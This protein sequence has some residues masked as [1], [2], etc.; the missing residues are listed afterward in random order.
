MKVEWEKSMDIKN[1]V[2]VSALKFSDIIFI[3]SY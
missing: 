1:K 3:S 2:S